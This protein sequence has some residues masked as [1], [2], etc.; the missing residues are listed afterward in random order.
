MWHERLAHLSRDVLHTSVPTV[1]ET[2]DF[3][4]KNMGECV[5]GKFGSSN[6][7]AKAFESVFSDMVGSTKRVCIG[8]TGY[9]VI[10]LDF[11]SGDSNDRFVRCKI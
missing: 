5:L 1:Y 2:G 3:D 8:K 10:L 6:K 4:L 11:H 9:F 7:K